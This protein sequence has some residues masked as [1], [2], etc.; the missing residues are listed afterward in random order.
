MNAR[1]F[2]GVAISRG[3]AVG[4]ARVIGRIAAPTE[5][6]AIAPNLIDAECRRLERAFDATQRE[7]T[8]VR[9]QLP[10]DVPS[11]VGDV[12]DMHILLL[13]DESFLADTRAL[14]R[15]RSVDAA[16]AL[17]LKHDELEAV[18]AA[19]QE[20]YLKSRFEDVHQVISRVQ[21]KL[22]GAKSSPLRAQRWAGA[23]VI[24]HEISPTDLS[25]FARL[26]VVGI[27]S[28]SGGPLSHS[29]ILA[30]SLKMPA[31]MGLSPTALTALR[32]GDPVALDGARGE[33]YVRPGLTLQAE[34]LARR[35][36]ESGRERALSRVRKL[37]A[38][39]RDGVGITLSAN[40]EID[41]EIDQALK[42]GADG[43]G[44]YRS[45]FLFVGRAT[46]PDEDEQ[47]AAYAQV[48]RKLAPRPVVIRTLDLGSDKAFL[49]GLKPAV[50]PALGLRAVRL[51]L[52][53]PALFK[54]QLRAL[55]RASIHGNLRI[56]VPMLSGLSEIAQVRRLIRQVESA[57]AAA[58]I[59]FAPNTPLGGMIEVPAA[60]IAAQA[61][62]R[63]LD[64]LSIGTNDLI[65]YTLAIDRGDE[66][67]AHLN[68]PLHPAILK[69]LKRVL[70]AGQ[71]EGKPV[72]LCGEMAADPTYTRVLLGLGLRDFSVSP[73]ALLELKSSIRRA[74]LSDAETLVAPMLKSARPRRYL[75]ALNDA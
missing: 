43:V 74:S 67:V 63:R 18:F 73:A 5:P 13:K 15:N 47:Y 57:L 55:K 27:A 14:I 75:A 4:R 28:V 33:L 9:R 69:L 39:T 50:N 7:L 54:T 20:A 46:P 68:D 31:L 16:W 49:P 22:Q 35:I 29:A 3:V 65:Q 41:A 71:R 48:L 37:P 38:V 21:L 17:K 40:V 58:G 45:E 64:F 34:L 61:F 42:A 32:D 1:C 2:S 72:S 52:R 19:M 12:I 23:I 6:I 8:R 24:A 62:A 60:A 66:S 53:H 10:R 30:R 44:L 25:E 11:E 26:G 51:C 56:L 59:A 70:D 36:K